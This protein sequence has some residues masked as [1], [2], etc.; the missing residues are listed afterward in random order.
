MR[1]RADR[2]FRTYV[3][4]V[5]LRASAGSVWEG[6]AARAMLET[7]CPVSQLDEPEAPAVEPEADGE[8]EEAQSAAE[9]EAPAEEVP[10]GNVGD[11]LDWVDGDPD[12]A[13]RALEAERAREHPRS[14][15]VKQLTDI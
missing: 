5:L 3:G 2:D 7:R 6:A 8:P 12:R 14:T 1:V 10:D 11:L 4:G 9:P 13:K 15:L